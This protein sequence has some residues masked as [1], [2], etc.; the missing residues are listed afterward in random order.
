MQLEERRLLASLTA[1]PVFAPDTPQA[2]VNAFE[3]NHVSAS[4]TGGEVGSEFAAYTYDDGARWTSTSTG[5]STPNQGQPAVVTWSIV[6]DGTSIYGYGGEPTSP[7]NLRATLNAAYGSMTAWLGHFQK[8]FDRWS[9]VSGV[10]YVYEPNDDG[11]AWTSGGIPSGAPGVR[12]DVRIAG[13]A[14]DG[15]AGTL[16]YNFYPNRGDMVIDTADASPGRYLANSLMLRNVVAHESGHGL[17]INHVN[18]VNRTKL[19]EPYATTAFDGPQFDDILAIQRGYGDRFEKNGG[20][21]TAARGAD[22]GTLALGQTITVGGDATMVAVSPT[23]SDFVTIDDDSDVDYFRFNVTGA[24]VVDLTLT[25][26][27]P[28]YDS[29]GTTFNSAAQSDL[30]LTLLASDG[31][32]VLGSSNRAGLGLSEALADVTL[33]SAGAYYVKITGANNAPQFYQ[34]NVSAESVLPPAITGVVW[35]DRNA[36]G[37]R[38]AN[39]PGLAGRTVFLDTVEPNGVLDASEPNTLTAANGSYSFASLAAGTYTVIAAA[40]AGWIATAPQSA[41][42]TVTLDAGAVADNVDFGSWS[43]VAIIDDGEAGFATTGSWINYTG[44]GYRNDVRYSAAGAGADAAAWTFTNLAPGRYRVSTTWSPYFNRATNAPFTVFDGALAAATVQVNQELA[45]NDFTDAGAAWEDLGVFT[46]TGSTLTVRL[47]DAANEY[48]IADAVRVERV[49]DLAPGPEIQV[50]DGGTDLADNTGSVDFGAVPRGATATKTFRVRNLGTQD[51]MLGAI[52]LPAGFSLL[53]GLNV[54]SL[55]PGDVA[56]FTVQLD[57]NAAGGYSSRLSLE[58]GDADEQ[59]FDV[60]LRGTVFTPPVVQIKDDGDT[61]FSVAGSWSYYTGAGFGKDVR[62]SGAGT[63][64]DVASWTFANVSPGQYRIAAT[65]FIY[66]NRATDAPYTI[67]DGAATLGTVRVNQELTPSDLTDAGVGWKDLGTFAITGSTLIVRLSDAANEYVI[68]DGVRIERV[69]DL[70]VSASMQSPSIVWNRRAAVQPFEML[71][72]S[73]FASVE[74]PDLRGTAAPTHYAP[75]NSVI[76]DQ[77]FATDYVKALQPRTVTKFAS[78][79]FTNHSSPRH[80][81][82]AREKSITAIAKSLSSS[83]PKEAPADCSKLDFAFASLAAPGA[84]E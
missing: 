41:A 72:S 8:V 83:Q 59:P 64:A 23:K 74:M 53:T 35:E 80:I 50:L 25:P 43:G 69:G 75:S 14:I 44:Q 36:N 60:A 5:A 84:Q 33:T 7:S 6:P 19:M 65:W 4:G 63:G 58:N 39:E 30:S 42:R 3:R 26:R 77:L 56:T 68:A 67:L 31:V 57:T 52:S 1:D 47:T 79:L 73:A 13:H 66:P 78:A 21:D 70:P 22:L 62:Y 40:P 29:N 15:S 38:D 51:L 55:A 24:S 82:F 11:S 10:T 2:I 71:I 27:G 46:V 49:G 20:N 12:G 61:G 28:T 9:Q 48:V 76:H 54:S 81:G 32:T 45:P 34:L 17:G 16:A 37:A 18:P